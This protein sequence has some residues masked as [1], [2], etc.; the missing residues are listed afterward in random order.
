MQSGIEDGV[1]T[2]ATRQTRK[3]AKNGHAV[4]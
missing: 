1:S 3:I 4:H 2:T